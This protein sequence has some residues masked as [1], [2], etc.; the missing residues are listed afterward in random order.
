LATAC[1]N[2]S[3]RTAGGRSLRRSW[4]GEGRE[5][6]KSEE[7]GTARLNARKENCALTVQ[8][9]LKLACATGHQK[10]FRHTLFATAAGKIFWCFHLRLLALVSGPPFGCCYRGLRQRLAAASA[11]ACGRRGGC[12]V[13]GAVAATKWKLAIMMT[14]G[15]LPTPQPHSPHTHTATHTHTDRRVEQIKGVALRARPTCG[16]RRSHGSSQH[17]NS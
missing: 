11:C 7:G 10:A 9:V 8:D 14:A 15:V 13:S 17:R 12:V 16:L 6:R 5:R 1:T 4:R 2:V 3:V